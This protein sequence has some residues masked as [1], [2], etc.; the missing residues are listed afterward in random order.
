M[1]LLGLAYS[2]TRTS[3]GL[4]TIF[5]EI[6]TQ[7]DI[8]SLFRLIIEL[9][10]QTM[11]MDESSKTIFLLV[12][13]IALSFISCIRA[14]IIGLSGCRER[15]PVT[16]KLMAALN[17]LFSCTTRILAMVLYFAVPLG[18]FNLLR[19][20]QGEQYPWN[21][22]MI[23]DVISPYDNGSIA[24]GNHDPVKWSLIDRWIK[25]RTVEPFVNVTLESSISITWN[26]DYLLSPPDYTFYTYFTLFEYFMIFLGQLCIH[27]LLNF[28]AKY[29]LSDHF[30]L[31]FN[32]LEKIIHSMENSNVPTSCLEWDD[33]DGDNQEHIKRMKANYKEVLIVTI[34]KTAFNLLLLL[35]II[36]LGK[37]KVTHLN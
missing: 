15:F 11:G 12:V 36:Y 13:S 2:E 35:P 3:E 16:S 34:I 24:V 20:L 23:H 33:A 18:L 25:N 28:M 19:H 17:A 10:L 1:I 27:I 30:R 7:E 6:P 29:W 37:F 8:Q 22:T 31:K 14:H 26:P 9:I 5:L 21:P 32:F 4:T